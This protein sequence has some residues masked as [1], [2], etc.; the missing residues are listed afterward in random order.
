MEYKKFIEELQKR[1]GKNKKSIDALMSDTLQIIKEHSVMMDSFS[2]QG[3]GTF[4]PRKKA[5]QD[6][7]ELGD[8]GAVGYPGRLQLYTGVMVWQAEQK[9]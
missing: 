3:F 4:E 1:L 8:Y 9:A 5:E 7:P 2:I 6:A